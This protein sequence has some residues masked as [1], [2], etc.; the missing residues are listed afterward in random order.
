MVTCRCSSSASTCVQTLIVPAL[1]TY[2]HAANR[3]LPLGYVLAITATWSARPRGYRLP[4]VPLSSGRCGARHPAAPDGA[5]RITSGPRGTPD[6]QTYAGISR[7]NAR[8]S[9]ARRGGTVAQL[10]GDHHFDPV[11]LPSPCA[12]GRAA[13]RADIDSLSTVMP[14]QPKPAPRRPAR[15][16]QVHGWKRASRSRRGS[17]SPRPTALLNTTRVTR[18]SRAQVSTSFRPDAHAAVADVGD[19]GRL[20]RGDLARRP[21]GTRSRSCR[22]SWPR[23]GA[24]LIEAQ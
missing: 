8:A 6:R 19:R 17:S 15:V 3:Q 16:G 1:A 24:L 18:P 12:H 22:S 13:G 7:G 2:R 5:A 23:H 11:H 9:T 20:R 14:S 10:L 21:S 4:S